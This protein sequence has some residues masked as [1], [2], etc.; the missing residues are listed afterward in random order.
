MSDPI[1][2]AGPSAVADGPMQAARSPAGL[3][4]AVRD[5]ASGY[6]D[7][8]KTETDRRKRSR[9]STRS[10]GFEKHRCSSAWLTWVGPSPLTVS[11]K[12]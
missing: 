7:R 11:G 3:A 9:S 2:P 1:R 4:D 8:R 12:L 10:V 6:A 5:Q